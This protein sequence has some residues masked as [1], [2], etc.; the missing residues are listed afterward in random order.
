MDN[1]SQV[2]FVLLTTSVRFGIY[3]SVEV[4]GSSDRNAGPDV[5]FAEGGMVATCLS[6]C[7]QQYV[8]GSL[9][10]SVAAPSSINGVDFGIVKLGPASATGALFPVFVLAAQFPEP[11]MKL[12]INITELMWK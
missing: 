4:V 7:S 9:S 10:A 8:I 5:L 11:V 3:R 1:T 12:F 6:Y 2:L